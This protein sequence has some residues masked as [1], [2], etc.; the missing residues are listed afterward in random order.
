MVGLKLSNLS[1][2]QI[3]VFDCPEIKLISKWEGKYKIKPFS[4][5]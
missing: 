3:I 1:Q 5:S 2:K 4:R